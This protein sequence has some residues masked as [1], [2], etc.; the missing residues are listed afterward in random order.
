MK[1]GRYIDVQKS[2]VLWR[3]ALR[4][5]ITRILVIFDIDVIHSS[6][7]FTC[8]SPGIKYPYRRKLDFSSVESL[9]TGRNVCYP[10]ACFP[11]AV[12]TYAYKAEAFALFVH[13]RVA[14]SHGDLPHTKG[15]RGGRLIKKRGSCF[16]LSVPPRN[17]T[18]TVP[19]KL[20]VKTQQAPAGKTV[21]V[22][23]NPSLT[24]SKEAS[25][26]IEPGAE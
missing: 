6:P 15:A 11:H 21:L 19:K 1:S 12:I 10:L 24:V 4:D 5:K 23:C 9:P 2:L 25:L 26:H 8:L 22:N 13:S 3:D 14:G 20:H 16:T 18:I 17:Q 7:V